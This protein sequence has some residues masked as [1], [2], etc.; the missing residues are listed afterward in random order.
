M[1]KFILRARCN[2]LPTPENRHRWYAE[3]AGTSGMCPKCPEK[4][5]TL[6]HILNDCFKNK[7]RV[8]LD[9]HNLLVTEIET[10]LLKYTNYAKGLHGG[11]IT[12]D[13]HL[14]LRG[15]PEDCRML[16]PDLVVQNSL[17]KKL[18]VFEFACPF[19][20]IYR[21]GDSLKYTYEY[22]E[23]NYGKLCNHARTQLPGWDVQ[24]VT[25]I[26]SSLGAIYTDMLKRLASVMELSPAQTVRT[27][28]RLSHAAINGSYTIGSNTNK[29]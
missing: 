3:R 4:H 9:R 12:K 10:A 14:N 24:Q 21:N 20:R 1:M 8:I 25:V 2:T 16:R 29:K 13:H 22:Q 23:G 17:A 27:G 5:G 19:A 7:D 26:V 28:Q 15:M 6:Q 18:Y 11:K